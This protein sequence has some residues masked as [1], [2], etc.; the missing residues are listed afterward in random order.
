MA[1]VLT[2][3]HKFADKFMSTLFKAFLTP[4]IAILLLFIGPI[5]TAWASALASGDYRFELEIGGRNR[6]YLVHVPLQSCVGPLPV[7]LN[8]H[9]G[10]GNAQS[11]IGKVLVCML[12]P[13]VMAISWYIQMVAGAWLN[14]Y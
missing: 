5:W 3:P 13:T 4:R 11:S 1:D 2:A 7:A 6:S 9:G 14:A 10:G 8:L 12:V